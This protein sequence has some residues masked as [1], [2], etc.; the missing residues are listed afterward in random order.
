MYLQFFGL[1]EAPFSPTPDPKFLFQS[2]RHREALAQLLYGVR[3]RKGFIVLTGEIGTGK[4]TLLRTLLSRLDADTHVA[5]IHNS[6]LEIEGLFELNEFL[7]DQHR[8]G[9]SPVLVIDE[10]QNLSL[11]TLEAVRLLSN[12]ET[13]SQ[14]LMQILLVGQPELRDKL[15]VPE[16]RQLKQRIGLRCHIGPLSPE[17]TRLYIRHRLRIAG[18]TDAGI[19]TDAAI[20]R[21][22]EYSHGTPR[23]INIV[24]DHCLL[25][26]FA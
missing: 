24:C 1:R 13:S 16:L 25:S 14:K 19:F 22:A 23:V 6:A 17:E 8:Q 21:I 2:T 26:G 18:A 11:A 12:F 15:N 3:E 10:A 20:Q 4:T 7:I 9:L 5:Y